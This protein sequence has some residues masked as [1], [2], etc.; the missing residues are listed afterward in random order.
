[1]YGPQ[2]SLSESSGRDQQLP[3]SRINLVQKATIQSSTTRN[4]SIRMY[5]WALSRS[6]TGSVTAGVDW[7]LSVWV[8]LVVRRLVRCS[9]ASHLQAG[10]YHLI[11]NIS[12]CLDVMINSHVD[13][14]AAGPGL[15]INV[16]HLLVKYAVHHCMIVI[17]SAVPAL[18]ISYDPVINTQVFGS[19]CSTRRCIPS[20]YNLYAEGIQRRVPNT[21]VFIT[22]SCFPCCCLV[23]FATLKQKFVFLGQS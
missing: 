23:N 8:V 22:R 7:L 11:S 20:T 2:R 6:A 13:E 3:V 19:S 17:A 18:L 16:L 12:S 15:P 4:S 9:G 21:W 5:V 1:M 10:R 14:T